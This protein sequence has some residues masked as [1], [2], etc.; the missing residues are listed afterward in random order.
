MTLETLLWICLYIWLGVGMIVFVAN[1][2]DGFGKALLRAVFW[3][4]RIL[5]EIVEGVLD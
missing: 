1:L 2:G 3:P 4:F 5:G